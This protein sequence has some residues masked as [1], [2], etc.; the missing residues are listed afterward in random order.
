MF[1]FAVLAGTAFF[2][3][4]IIFGFP[5]SIAIIFCA[6]SP[7]L[8]NFQPQT[9][10]T[11]AS[12][13]N[14]A[15]AAQISHLRPNGKIQRD[16]Y[17]DIELPVGFPKEQLRFLQGFQRSSACPSVLPDDCRPTLFCSSRK[18]RRSLKRI[19]SPAIKQ[20][21]RPL[22]ASRSS[23][24]GGSLYFRAAYRNGIKPLSITHRENR[25]AIMDFVQE[26]IKKCGF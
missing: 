6:N 19:A 2:I 17:S 5:S 22:L 14:Q 16:K 10:N 3:F 11:N 4:A 25:S 23:Q 1:D 8:P 20:D 12:C 7:H 13:I 26:N 21:N 9:A 15:A 24:S 18:S